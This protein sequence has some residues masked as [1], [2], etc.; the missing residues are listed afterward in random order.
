LSARCG[1]FT[2]PAADGKISLTK[3]QRL[4][5]DHLTLKI[6]SWAR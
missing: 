2:N 1:D 3:N 5:I 6:G 4:A